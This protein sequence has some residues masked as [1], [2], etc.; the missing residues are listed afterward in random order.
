MPITYPLRYLHITPWQA[1]VDL[2][3]RTEQIDTKDGECIF[4]A[5]DVLNESSIEVTIAIDYHKGLLKLMPPSSQYTLVIE[6]I[7]IGDF[8]GVYEAKQPR[9]CYQNVNALRREM[10]KYLTSVVFD[11]HDMTGD[12]YIPEVMTY[13]LQMAPRSLRWWGSLMVLFPK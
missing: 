5:V 3:R 7:H 6:R 10:Q 1:I 12:E 4:V 13:E 2:V 8:I 11:D 9:E